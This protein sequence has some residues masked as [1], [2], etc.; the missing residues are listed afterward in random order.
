MFPTRHELLAQFRNP[1]YAPHPRIEGLRTFHCLSRWNDTLIVELPRVRVEIVSIDY[2]E[3]SAEGSADRMISGPLQFQQDCYRL[4]YQIDGTGILQNAT[5]NSFGTA[6]PGLLGIME[7]GERHTYLHQKGNFECFQMLFSLL[8]SQN[9]KCYWNSGIEGKNVLDAD[10][11]LYFENL[12]F[13]LL[14]VI[15]NDKEMLGLATVSRILEIL[16][17]LFNNGLLIIQ[18]SQFPKNKAKSLVVKAKQFMDLHYAQME[19]QE[20]LEKECGV[21]INYLNIIFKKEFGTT[22]Y[23]YMLGV[24]MEHAKFML[25][26]SRDSVSDIADKI[27]YPNAN[28]F[29]RVFRKH[30]GLAPLDYRKKQKHGKG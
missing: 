30:T 24:R 11:R 23:Q 21:D 3:H 16:V 18:E 7:R 19:H 2:L 26:I 5:R 14:Q 6:H 9:A 10:E 22:L 13:D 15:S 25:E 29:T 8:P 20:E 28:S 4:W 17:V 12:I 27:G 1:V